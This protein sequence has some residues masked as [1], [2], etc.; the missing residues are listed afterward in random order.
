MKPVRTYCPFEI[1]KRYFLQNIA[2][3]IHACGSDKSLCKNITFLTS[4]SEESLYRPWI[5]SHISDLVILQNPSV[6][7]MLF[8]SSDPYRTIGVIIFSIEGRC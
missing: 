6:T 2:L 4:T 8:H 1:Y 7:V 5:D 3:E